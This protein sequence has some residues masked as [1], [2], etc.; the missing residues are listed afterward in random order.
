[1][2][3]TRQD[4]ITNSLRIMGVVNAGFD[5]SAEDTAL[6]G[7]VY[8][9]LHARLR[10]LNRIWWHDNDCVPDEAFGSISGILAG[11]IITESA[12][13]GLSPQKRADVYAAFDKGTFDINDMINAGNIPSGE[14][15]KPEWF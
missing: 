15:V 14:R 10:Q 4:V 12:D 7:K 2:T 8:D 13:Y 6:V 3:A 5:E 11:T 1:M 9:G